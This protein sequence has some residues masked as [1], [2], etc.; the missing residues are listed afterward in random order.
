MKNK[1]LF[2]FGIFAIALAIAGLVY[3]Q[4]QIQLNLNTTK[5]VYICPKGGLLC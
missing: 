5:E 4:T 2:I 1:L 3:S